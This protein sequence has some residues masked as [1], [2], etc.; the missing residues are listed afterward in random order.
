MTQD[1]ADGPQLTITCTWP[2]EL[3]TE[4]DVR[5]LGDAWIAAL[6]TLA[7]H[8]DD[9]NAGGRTPSDLALVSL[10]QRE[11]DRIEEEMPVSDILPL[12]SLQEG[13]LF[14]ALYDEQGP[15]VYVVQLAL[16]LEGQLDADRLRAAGQALLR[17]YPNL[18]AGFVVRGAGQPVQVIPD[19]VELPWRETDLR[20]RTTEARS[21]ELER[22][23]RKKPPAAS[24]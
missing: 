17:R 19:S 11:I 13:L 7:E 1:D 2:R 3:L 22:L 18:S 9:P 16:E 12:S 10:D 23:V 15:D 24:T 8:A 5:E 6:N 4:G 14:H 21:A 20:D